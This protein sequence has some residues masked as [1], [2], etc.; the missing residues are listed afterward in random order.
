MKTKLALALLCSLA[1]PGC[2]F[3]LGGGG[4]GPIDEPITPWEPSEPIINNDL[5]ISQP[6]LEG[7]L[8]SVSAAGEG[9]IASA[10]GDSNWTNI[11][12]RARGERGVI[13]NS[14]NIEGD[15]RT[16]EIGQTYRSDS[17]DYDSTA[18]IYF[19]M[20]GCSGPAD[21]AW[22]FDVPAQEVEVTVEEG[23]EEGTVEL[24]YTASFGDGSASRGSFVMPN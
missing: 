16:L 22:D 18:G 9:Y 4:G 23:P 2:Y 13:M 21:N 19:S 5:D 6:Q 15:V 1:I 20:I 10:Y 11:D 24:F 3:D 8:G 12:L 17:F 14:L 7:R